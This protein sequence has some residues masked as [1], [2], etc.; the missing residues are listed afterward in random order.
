[1][2][3]NALALP[4][5]KA[6]PSIPPVLAQAVDGFEPM[7]TIRGTISAPAIVAA[8]EAIDALA[9]YHVPAP[10]TLV[11]FWLRKLR[12][13]VAPISDDD[14]DGRVEAVQSAAGDLP[15]WLWCAET[16][17]LAWRAWKFFPTS[18]EIHDLLA[19][20]A[21]RETRKLAIV[22]QIASCALPAPAAPPA[23]EPE[24][25]L[26]TPE[27]VE[28]VT[29][30]VARMKADLLGRSAAVRDR[31]D[32][33]PPAKPGAV[34]PPSGRSLAENPL[35]LEAR[36]EQAAQRAKQASYKIFPV[37]NHNASAENF[38]A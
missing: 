14:F 11:E 16:L 10:P 17:R 35:V 30:L 25:A 20:I 29:A 8:R 23:P 26:A 13:G 19:P 6:P 2:P 4:D 12:Q 5:Q 18:S 32:Y 36:R 38:D 7:Q 24:P 21:W 22:R 1:M 34:P 28:Q 9:R 27:K 15:A 33:V 3:S 37:I 31:G